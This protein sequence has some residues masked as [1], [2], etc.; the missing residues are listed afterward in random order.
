[1]SDASCYEKRCHWSSI[2]NGFS[3]LYVSI[4]GSWSSI[5]N[6]PMPN[7]VSWNSQ[8]NRQER[9]CGENNW[10]NIMW[11]VSEDEYIDSSEVCY[12]LSFCAS[13]HLPLYYAWFLH[14]HAWPFL[15][16]TLQD[17]NWG[18][19]RCIPMFAATILLPQFPF[20]NSLP[21]DHHLIL[22]AESLPLKPY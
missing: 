22:V 13:L 18:Y 20:I 19:I 2:S 4:L 9:T 1:M 5:V 14:W 7:S 10:N 6:D 17:L 16:M 11:T 15:C 3:S 8:F 12:W 21:Y